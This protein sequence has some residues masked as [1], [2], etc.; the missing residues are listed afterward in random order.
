MSA[1]EPL[2]I[3][4]D[5]GW[6]TVRRHHVIVGVLIILNDRRSQ[7]VVSDKALFHDLWR[8][9]LP[10]NERRAVVIADPFLLGRLKKE[11]V[12]APAFWTLAAGGYALHQHMIRRGQMNNSR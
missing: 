8:I 2:D 5:F 9:I 12:N 7:V 1:Q 6:R 4:H 3:A 10:A 11:V